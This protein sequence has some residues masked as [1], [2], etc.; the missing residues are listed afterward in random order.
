MHKL[1]K[2]LKKKIKGKKGK[3]KEDDLFDPAI[4][5]QYRR[6]KAAAA[7]AAAAK[8]AA[9]GEDFDPSAEENGSPTAANGATSSAEP[10]AD[11]KDSEEWEKFK[12]LTSGNN[13]CLLSSIKVIFKC[14][15][16]R[17]IDSLLSAYHEQFC[18]GNSA[19][20]D[21]I[22]MVFNEF[23]V[24]SPSYLLKKSWNGHR[25]YRWNISMKFQEILLDSFHAGLSFT[26]YFVL[27]R[28]LSE[29]FSLY[30]Y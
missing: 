12:L 8:A 19:V 14:L 2:G 29:S 5:E 13:N 6:D 18:W 27:I 26:G 3:E 30:Y 11:K 28:M 22:S 9:S 24:H 10:G 20:F 1:G 23:P 17:S 7:A 16:S 4:L 25:T 15:K 21:I